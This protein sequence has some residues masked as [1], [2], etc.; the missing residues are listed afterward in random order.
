MHASLFKNVM[1]PLYFI[2][3]VI[4]TQE[5]RAYHLPI[6]AV[7]VNACETI[8]GWMIIHVYR[9]KVDPSAAEVI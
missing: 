1:L 7:S 4:N 2:D 5:I 6:N 9:L 8:C 3:S